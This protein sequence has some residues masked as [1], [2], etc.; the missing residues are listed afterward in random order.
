MRSMGFARSTHPTDYGPL[1]AGWPR[2]GRRTLCLQNARTR[3]IIP[4]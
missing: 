2:E 4:P 1:N 3:R